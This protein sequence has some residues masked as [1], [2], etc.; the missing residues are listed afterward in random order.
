MRFPTARTSSRN[1]AESGQLG[2]LY[3]LKFK[4]SGTKTVAVSQSEVYEPR[5][6]M[7]STFHFPALRHATC[8]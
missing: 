2:V 3:M 6:F 8:M 1:D 5:P 4:I 7:A